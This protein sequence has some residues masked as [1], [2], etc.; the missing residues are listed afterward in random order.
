[1]QLSSMKLLAPPFSHIRSTPA[2]AKAAH[3]QQ[4]DE[5]RDRSRS[6]REEYVKNTTKKRDCHHQHCVTLLMEISKLLNT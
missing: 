1:M 6:S 3:K 2:Q 5:I 4:S